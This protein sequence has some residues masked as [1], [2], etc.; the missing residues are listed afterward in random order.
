[1]IILDRK[2]ICDYN[3]IMWWNL[4]NFIWCIIVKYL[5]NEKTEYKLILSDY[6]ISNQIY[7]LTQ[8]FT[9]HAGTQ[10]ILAPEILRAE[11]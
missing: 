9:T 10:I 3:E 6:G 8:K 2:R 4:W 5:N 1:M 7:S 11:K